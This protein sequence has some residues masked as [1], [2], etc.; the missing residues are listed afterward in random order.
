MTVKI[1]F[2]R[3][4]HANNS[5][6]THNLIWTSKA[7]EFED[8]NDEDFGWNHFTCSSRKSKMLYITA[9]LYSSY[10]S[11]TKINTYDSIIESEELD[12][13]ILAQF[14]KWV[15][16][17]IPMLKGT[18]I[19]FNPSN[20]Y[21]D[22]QSYICFP[23]Y[24]KARQYI[25]VEFARD[26]VKEMVDGDYV[27]LGGNDNG[28]SEHPLLG[29]DEKESNAL[30]MVYRMITDVG[31]GTVFCVKDHK[32]GDYVMSSN[33]GTGNVMRVSFIKKDKPVKKDDPDALLEKA[34]D[35]L[36]LEEKEED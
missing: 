19:S 18:S 8:T 31:D 14:R 25:N 11:A 30:S 13:F 35:K 2:F 9:C 23:Y 27:I 33:T 26:F 24:R 17:H 22:H 20:N 7:K 34:L 5:S 15:K 21:V 3:E 4:G 6:S 29:L 12:S 16:E 32:I 28:E 1:S 36:E 10:C